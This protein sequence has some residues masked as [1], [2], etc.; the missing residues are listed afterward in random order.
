MQRAP[1]LRVTVLAC[2]AGL[3]CLALALGPGALTARAGPVLPVIDAPAV[4]SNTRVGELPCRWTA[5]INA[6]PGGSDSFRQP[7]TPAAVARLALVNRFN[8]V[9]IDVPIVAA[10]YSDAHVQMPGPGVHETYNCASA[11]GD[12][13]SPTAAEVVAIGRQVRRTNPRSLVV[14]RPMLAL[15]GSCAPTRYYPTGRF[16]GSG[17]RKGAPNE[18]AFAHFYT[19]ILL[20][21]A[22]D[23]VAINRSGHVVLDDVSQLDCLLNDPENSGYAGYFNRLPG[24][25]ARHYPQL[26]QM[27]SLDWTFTASPGAGCGWPGANPTKRP[28]NELRHNATLLRRVG[29]VGIQENFPLPGGD[30]SVA[31]VVR[32]WS[33]A[34]TAA[35]GMGPLTAAGQVEALHRLTGGDVVISAIGYND[36][37]NNPAAAP[38]VVPAWCNKIYGHRQGV[39]SASEVAAEKRADTAAYCYWTATEGATAPWFLGLWWWNRDFDHSPYINP[40]D[41]T[42]G[43]GNLHTSALVA[44]RA[45]QSGADVHACPSG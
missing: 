27:V 8:T 45:F 3:M 15:G 29:I 7:G 9:V 20:R 32:R 4:C 10:N 12:Y 37:S 34:T 16:W 22:A 21:L 18:A 28:V 35:L 6:Y 44:L 41:L 39:P 5:G 42:W 2:A 40:Y 11:N 1:L 30:P 19:A 13:F 25:I 38:T 26:A 24:Q 43:T 23:A 14:I 36:C 31:G 17:Y 33:G